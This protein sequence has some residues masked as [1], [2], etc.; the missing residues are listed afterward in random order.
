MISPF[1]PV[2]KRYHDL[3]VESLVQATEDRTKV[4]ESITNIIGSLKDV[5]PEIHQTEGVH[6]NPIEL[7]I[8]DIKKQRQIE[9]ILDELVVK[10]FFQKALGSMEERL[11]DNNTFHLR[12][13]KGSALKGE[14]RLWTGGPSIQIRLKVATFPSSREGSLEILEQLLYQ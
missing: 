5:E 8:F 2:V 6:G 1:T 14:P 13:D 9:K 3:R 12:V 7:I 11:D 10:S 4:L